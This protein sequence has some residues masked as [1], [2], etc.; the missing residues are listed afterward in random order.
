MVAPLSRTL[1][2]QPELLIGYTCSNLQIVCSPA[3]TGG[4]TLPRL[5]VKVIIPDVHGVHGLLESS[6]HC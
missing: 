2:N 4:E 3:S 5:E 1:K 6:C